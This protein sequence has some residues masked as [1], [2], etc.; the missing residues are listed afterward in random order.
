MGGSDQWG[1]IVAGIELIRRMKGTQAYGI[2]FPLLETSSGR[3]MGKTESG[4]VWL[5][6]DR[7]SPYDYYQFWVNTEDGDVARFLR[8]F[9]LLPLE[10]IG[11]VEGLEGADLNPAKVVLAFETTRM[12][13][14]EEAAREAYR[15]SAV[16]GARETPAD[17]LPSS[18]IPREK[19]A[20][21]DLSIPT[22]YVEASRL[23][24]GIAAYEL[25]AEAGLCA[26]RAEAR[27]LI[28]QGG[29]YCG[30]RRIASHDEP[31]SLVD[32]GPDG[33]LLRKGKKLY[34]RIVPRE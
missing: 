17:L 25:L 2:T 28:A 29:A 14:G 7:T 31:I 30:E 4:T 19:G 27:R 5:D 32:Q 9:T 21:G 15:S 3:K 18:P 34:R 10:E 8:L 11:H 33:I 16:F 24:T 20:A 12:A 23:A 6:P 26:T 22:T 1:N 13:H